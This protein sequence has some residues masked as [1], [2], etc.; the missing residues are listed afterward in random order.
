MERCPWCGNDELY[1]RYHDEEWGVPVHGDRKQ[2][3]FLVL[4]AAQAGLSWITILRKREAYRQAYADFAPEV[5]ARYGERE[6]EGLLSNAG[7]V[8]NER[9]IRASI[10]NAQRFLEVQR[11]FGS[12]DR[13]LWGFVDHKP[14]RN[15]WKT[16]DEIPSK[17]PLSEEISQDLIRRGFS[18]VGPTVIY[19][20]IQAVGLVND[21]LVDCFRYRELLDRA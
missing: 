5:V 20:H 7:I 13:Y 18:F 1:V 21:H 19:S 17:T 3:E 11:E 9:K 6:V 8:R 10:N 15:R 4:E 12:F 16:L 14:I 2:F